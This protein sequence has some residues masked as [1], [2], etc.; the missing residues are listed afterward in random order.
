[1]SL[2]EA[3]WTGL[4]GPVSSL[5]TLPTYPRQKSEGFWEHRAHVKY[6]RLAILKGRKYHLVSN[7][8][9]VSLKFPVK[10]GS[11]TAQGQ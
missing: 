9:G 2:P 6:S 11:P 7:N 1:M 10:T 3:T 8:I 5:W 4:R